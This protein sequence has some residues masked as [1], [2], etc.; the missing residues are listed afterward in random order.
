M[1]EIVL[2]IVMPVYNESGTV[3]KV[4][5]DHLNIVEECRD[6]LKS[7]EIICL[8]DASSDNSYSILKNIEAKND[9][10][11]ILQH[12]YNQGI[13]TSFNDL[14]HAAKGTHIYVT[15]SDDQWPSENLKKLLKSLIDN[16]YDLVIGVRE[17]RK[18]IYSLWRRI[19]SF[20]FN[21]IPEVLYGVK[22]KDANGIKLGKREFFTMRLYST[23]FF[24]EIERIIEAKK[25]GA[26]IGFE[27]IEFLTRS[28]GKAK[29]ARWNN[30]FASLK[31]LGR[32]I[33]RTRFVRK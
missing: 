29:G 26:H 2:S 32:Y 8:D 12:K 18:E 10:V 33:W 5:E 4:I 1:S 30:I 6:L 17:N 21:F 7:W 24:A 3:K 28:S 19:L 23:S 25:R 9:N 15:A 27:P 13:A 16:S 20:S 22:I 11:R 14:F 31:D